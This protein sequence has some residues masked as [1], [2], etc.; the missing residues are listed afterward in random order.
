MNDSRE[1]A[2]YQAKIADIDALSIPDD[3]K[4]TLKSSVMLY[5][6]SSITQKMVDDQQAK[7]DALNNV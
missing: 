5:S 2:E 7:V 3:M 6:P 4:A 1:L